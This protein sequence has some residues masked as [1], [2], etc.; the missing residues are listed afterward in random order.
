ML[1]CSIMRQK[2]KGTELVRQI[3]KVSKAAVGRTR[4]G[5]TLKKLELKPVM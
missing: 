4:R 2:E 5:A 1:E 3:E